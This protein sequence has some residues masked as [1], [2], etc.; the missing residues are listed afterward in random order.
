M[1]LTWQHEESATIQVR[2]PEFAQRLKS[3]QVDKTVMAKMNRTC[4]GNGNLTPC[5]YYCDYWPCDVKGGIIGASMGLDY[6]STYT[7]SNTCLYDP[8][9]GCRRPLTCS[10]LVLM[11]IVIR[12]SFRLRLTCMHVCVHTCLPICMSAYLSFWLSGC[13]HLRLYDDCLAC[14]R[15][16]GCNQQ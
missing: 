1:V 4:S 2:L 9:M 7:N 5:V 11:S 3:N 6:L 8:T 10:T 13:R 16:Y 15:F 12:R 14:L